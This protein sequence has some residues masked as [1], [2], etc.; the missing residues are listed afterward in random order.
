MDRRVPNRSTIADASDEALVRAASV[1]DRDAFAVLVGRYGP[2]MY[3]YALRLVGDENDAD[4][5]AQ[6][7]FVSA[8]RGL[9]TFAGRSSLK[10]WLYRLVHRRAVDTQRHRRPSPVSDD[11]LSTL[12]PAASDDPLQ[13]VLDGEL[14]IALQAVLHE[15]P[16][17]QRATWLLREVE[18]MTYEEIAETVAVSVGSVRGHLYRARRTVAERMALWR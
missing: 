17:Q 15:L 5:I 3:R 4:E 8:W 2:G 6:E 7:A 11:L 14:L 12:T 10:T 1:G 9:R 18:D 13:Q 16:W